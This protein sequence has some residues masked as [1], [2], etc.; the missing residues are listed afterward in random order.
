M[1]WTQQLRSANCAIETL[2]LPHEWHLNS[3][4]TFKCTVRICE[5]SKAT[6]F[7][8]QRDTGVLIFTPQDVDFSAHLAPLHTQNELS[9][10]LHVTTTTFRITTSCSL[11]DFGRVCGA[12]RARGGSVV[13][14]TTGL[15]CSPLPPLT[16]HCCLLWNSKLRTCYRFS[17]CNCLQLA[18]KDPWLK[19]TVILIFTTEITGMQRCSFTT[20]SDH[21][22]VLLFFL[23]L[24]SHFMSIS[25][26]GLT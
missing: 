18:L 6:S 8:S 14:E 4:D 11:C 9:F 3:F 23:A 25:C 13:T 12:F 16:P 7:H 1:V 21:T 15:S 26:S 22:L 2:N 5:F 20:C 10:A 19:N 24:R 17:S